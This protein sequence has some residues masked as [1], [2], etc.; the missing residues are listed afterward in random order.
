M[1]QAI[2]KYPPGFYE[3]YTSNSLPNNPEI[4]AYNQ[5]AISTEHQQPDYSSYFKDAPKPVQTGYY[6]QPFY[7]GFDG[8]P[9]AGI[10]S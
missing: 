3:P 5:P 2:P 9:S 7:S 1:Y 4:N 6:L 10:I 8:E